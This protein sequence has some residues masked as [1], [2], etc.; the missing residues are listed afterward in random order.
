MLV[1]TTRTTLVYVFL[2]HNSLFGTRLEID[3]L[4]DCRQKTC[5]VSLLGVRVT[6]SQ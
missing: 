6:M 2:H 5:V 3:Y 1:Y 4:T